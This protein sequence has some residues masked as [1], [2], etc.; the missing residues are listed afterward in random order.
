MPLVFLSKRLKDEELSKAK[1]IIEKYSENIEYTDIPNDSKLDLS[2][3][4]QSDI[5]TNQV[6]KTLT[7]T[8]VCLVQMDSKGINP[9]LF[10]PRN[11]GLKNLF[12]FGMKISLFEINFAKPI[13][14]LVNSMGGTIDD[15]SDPNNADIILT[16]KK[17]KTNDFSIPLVSTEWVYA[18]SNQ[19]SEVPYDNFIVF[20]EKL[21]SKRGHLKYSSQLTEPIKKVQECPI[22]SVSQIVHIPD[23]KSEIHVKNEDKKENISASKLNSSQINQKT[24]SR[25]R[26]ILNCIRPAQRCLSS[27]SNAPDSLEVIHDYIP[28]PSFDDIE[29]AESSQ[30]ILRSPIK[31]NKIVKVSHF[32]EKI[33]NEFDANLN[34]GLDN[35][36]EKEK[37]AIFPVPDTP[38]RIKQNSPRI[39]TSPLSNHTV[40]PKL[41]SL[42]TFI[43]K[44]SNKQH[45]KPS[46]IKS[47]PS[48]EE[49]NDFSQIP[50]DDMGDELMNEVYYDKTKESQG[51]SE[52]HSTQLDEE[53]FFEML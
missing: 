47:L 26:N 41:K 5:L 8:L 53:A 20:K 14:S 9:F 34:P 10:Q 38:E 15:S 29:A 36:K 37:I 40:S 17:Y 33:D 4:T 18:I 2:V 21:S 13:I 3:R 39:K 12:L 7:V 43:Q 23:M 6:Y 1:T 52:Q 22:H 48:M 31:E 50:N 46:N 35:E 16:D 51:H 44:K 32:R 49:L 42:M 45:K 30:I 19:T 11:I 28:R 25:R 27:S 24:K